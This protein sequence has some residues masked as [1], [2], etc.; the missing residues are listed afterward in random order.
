MLVRDLEQGGYPQAS[1]SPA[2][3][4]GGSDPPDPPLAAT[5]VIFPWAFLH[6]LSQKLSHCSRPMFS[7]ISSLLKNLL[8]YC[9]SK[10]YMII[11]ENLENT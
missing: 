5:L 10:Q 2:G 7:P 3:Q 4:W 6:L 1:G 9:G 11:V 8:T